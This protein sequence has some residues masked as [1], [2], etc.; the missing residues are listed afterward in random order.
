MLFLDGS[1]LAIPAIER[2][3]Q[4][5]I[6]TI[7]ANYY[8]SSVSIGK[9]HADEAWQIDF[10]DIERLAER[11]RKAHVDGVF[12][13]WTDSHLPYYAALCDTL[14][15][16]CYGTEEQ[17]SVSIRKD[18]FKQA[19]RRN[20]VP[21]AEEY[22]EVFCENG[23]ADSE[24]L[25][26][27]HFPVLVKPADN[28]GSRGVFI[29]QNANELV[30]NY[31]KALKSSPERKVLIEEYI[32]G[33]HVNMYYTLSKGKAYLSAMADRYVDYLNYQSAPVPVLLV[34]PSSFLDEYEKSV[35][36]KVKC[37][38]RDLGMKDGVAF[39]QGFR[40][41]DGRFVI[42]EMGYRLNGGGTY[43]LINA[44]SGYDQIDMLIRFALT[45]EMGNEQEL[46]RN[47]PHFNK[48][49]IMYVISTEVDPIRSFS[50][51]EK[52]REISQVTDVIPVRFPMEYTNSLGSHSR[53]AAYVLF[54]AKDKG[55]AAGVLDQIYEAVRMINENGDPM[56][57]PHADLSVL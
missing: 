6:H 9:Q 21:V 16:Y 20:G 50:G 39:V 22:E 41:E 3:K 52:V 48:K 51:L 15:L 28:S 18:A 56:S 30:N 44:C 57:F 23:G 34:H 27:I 5:K 13:G 19:C 31:Q 1:A 45:G 36:P 7:V 55:E 49:A 24:K 25:S 47:D 10:T 33:Q 35:D 32:T 53:I 17:F 12:Q 38:F 46:Q 42:Y 37:M 43:S 4:L 8:D 14:G 54:L 11:A 29:C 26:K 2:A 40:R